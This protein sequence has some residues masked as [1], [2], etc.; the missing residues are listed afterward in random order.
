MKKVVLW[1]TVIQSPYVV[2]FPAAQARKQI[3]E[4]LLQE[5]EDEH[6][7]IDRLGINGIYNRG[8]GCMI[9]DR[10][11]CAEPG[12]YNIMLKPKFKANFRAGYWKVICLHTKPLDVVP[13]E[14]RV[15]TSN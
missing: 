6:R 2:D 11:W 10:Q 14:M 5:D 3:L 1:K 7:L 8:Y 4:E 13:R 12:E 15:C 9:E